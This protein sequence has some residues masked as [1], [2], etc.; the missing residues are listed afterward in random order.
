M[1]TEKRIFSFVLMICLFCSMLSITAFAGS[2]M[3]IFVKTATDRHITL[4]VEPTDKIKDVK[5]KIYDLEGIS[6]DEQIL[7][8]AGKELKDENTLQDYF[9]QKDST[10]HLVLRMNPMDGSGTESDPYQITSADELKWFA[11][12]VN[13]GQN[14]ICGKLM[15]DI[16]LNRVPW[17]P[18]GNVTTPFL[19]IFDGN[20]FTISQLYVEGGADNQ[21][22]FGYC[23]DAAIKNVKT[24]NGIING[25]NS[26]GGIVGHAE[27]TDITNCVNGNSISSGGT[28]NGGIV[29][30][31][32]RT[33]IIDCINNGDILKGAYQNGGIAG[34]A[35]NSLIDCCIN[36][37]NISNTDHS[38][39]IAAY[40]TNG[41]VSN[42]LNV[43][44]IT[45]TGGFFCYTAGIVAD[46][47]GKNSVVKNCLNLGNLSG[48]G[49]EG[50]RV[51]TIVCANDREG[52]YA[53]NC[54]SK[55]GLGELGL[56]TNSKNVT[57][58]ELKSGEVAWEL[59]EEKEGV[60]K[61]NIGT[62]LYP[63]FSGNS[64]YKLADGTFGSACDHTYSQN[65]PTCTQSAVCSVCN[66]DIS[67]TGHS[68]V[69]YIA[70]NDATCTKD[71]TK[72]AKCDRC[73]EKDTVSDEGS[74]VPHDYKDK[75]FGDDTSHWRECTNC[76]NKTDKADHTLE[77]IV[78]KES[79]S[80]EKGSKHEE[81]SVCGY[82]KSSVEMPVVTPT[83]TDRTN[84]N[85]D[86]VETG[87]QTNIGL[88]TA[89]FTMSILV[90]AIL[91]ICKKK[92]VLEVE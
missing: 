63:N 28:Y 90:M 2:S 54:Y 20:G 74:M 64:V 30:R 85:N 55:V 89:L 61:Q 29:G 10:L 32:I 67:A 36:Y 13:D 68:F 44:N 78:D 46:N 49:G 18:I 84:K 7:V 6:P 86:S 3:Q 35:E 26:S 91:T 21:G 59:N 83:N 27:D 73:D 43:G 19:G 12:Q 8:F 65:K 9:I 1:K 72:T 16:D 58:E 38:G 92:K 50:C 56:A 75:W 88:Y 47:E 11:E 80:T 48:T 79:T 77:W 17:T 51:N 60:W 71:G 87:D 70:N 52:T 66:A 25:N 23:K 82:K 24:E 81:C 53:E 37:G 31:C 41:T 14:N 22:L 40:N 62:D 5:A 69:N 76:D 33:E 39:G 57:E 45:T 15:N 42:C 34:S 4:D